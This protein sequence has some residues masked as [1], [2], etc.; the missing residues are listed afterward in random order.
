MP[1]ASR[2]AIARPC[3]SVRLGNLLRVDLLIDPTG[4]V[5]TKLEMAPIFF[6]AQFRPL[7]ECGLRRQRRS[8]RYRADIP[9][10]RP[11]LQRPNR[12]QPAHRTPETI[13]FDIGA[14]GPA[15]TRQPKPLNRP[16]PHAS[17]SA[18][19]AASIRRGS[20]HAAHPRGLNPWEPKGRLGNRRKAW[21]GGKPGRWKPM[22]IEDARLPVAFLS[23]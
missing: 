19:I 17:D 4:A 8:P 9:C 14:S 11:A 18:F 10:R 7:P 20:I 21:P 16:A 23:A 12:P 13:P 22:T 1:R 3:R 5:S 15:R 6:C 2:S